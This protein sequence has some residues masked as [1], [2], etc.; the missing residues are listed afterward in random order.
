MVFADVYQ[1]RIFKLLANPTSVSTIRLSDV[2]FAYQILT[3]KD[4]YMRIQIIHRKLKK[5]NFS[6]ASP[7]VI[8][9]FQN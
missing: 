8:F 5:G 2:T 4:D 9:T 6:N 7:E 3:P 1:N